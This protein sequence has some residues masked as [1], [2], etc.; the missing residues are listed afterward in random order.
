[1]E[2]ARRAFGAAVV[3][4]VS[5]G[6]LGHSSR[7]RAYPD[8]QLVK[9]EFERAGFPDLRIRRLHAPGCPAGCTNGKP[10]KEPF[11]I[12]ESTHRSLLLE[13]DVYPLQPWRTN[14]VVFTHGLAGIYRGSLMVVTTPEDVSKAKAA[15]KCI[16]RGGC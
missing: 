3:A 16:D 12:V 14:R 4:L 5:A 15:L 2:R 9:N 13:V 8:P 11:A 10:L 1:V 7:A 6:C